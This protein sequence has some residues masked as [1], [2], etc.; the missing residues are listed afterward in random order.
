MKNRSINKL[1]NTFNSEIE[2]KNLTKEER[3]ILNEI[4]QIRS[5]VYSYD[6]ND[7]EWI[8][9]VRPYKLAMERDELIR[10]FIISHHLLT[11]EFLNTELLKY[12]IKYSEKSKHFKLF[13]DFILD[14][15]SYKEKIDLAYKANI[16]SE[17]AYK[18]L[19]K[20]NVLRNKC[21]HRW[22]LKDKKVKLLYEGEDLLNIKNFEQFVD[23]I[24]TAH[25]VLWNL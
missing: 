7:P 23:D 2:M 12:F 21:A 1:Q 24:F 4:N 8:K 19:E 5:I 13:E 14:K 18:F 10:D 3:K 22:F 6:K 25:E 11:E 17:G 20:L 15:L 16:I 9:E